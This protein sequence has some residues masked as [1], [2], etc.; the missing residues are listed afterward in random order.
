MPSRWE[1][2]EQRWTVN[3]GIEKYFLINIVRLYM[4][5]VGIEGKLVLIKIDS[6]PRCKKKESRCASL[7]NLGTYLYP[8]VPNTTSMVHETNQADGNSKQH[9][10]AT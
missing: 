7:H 10:I 8:V 2:F 1:S 3:S 4:D 5:V 9:S 6:S